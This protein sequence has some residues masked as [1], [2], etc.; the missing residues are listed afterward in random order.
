MIYYSE[1]Q[2]YFDDYKYLS[3]LRKINLNNRVT[4]LEW[5]SMMSGLIFVSTKN[6]NIFLF[7]LRNLLN[8]IQKI[9][10]KKIIP[11]I[12]FFNFSYSNKILLI[13]SNNVKKI[14]IVKIK[15]FEFLKAH[16]IQIQNILIKYKKIHSQNWISLNKYNDITLWKILYNDFS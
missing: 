15:N 3:N 6:S 16:V 14:T 11:T 2:I 9:K 4:N 13:S 12:D 5:Y 8:P 1:K 10:L 7:D